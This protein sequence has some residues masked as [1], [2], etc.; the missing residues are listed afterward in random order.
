[1]KVSFDTKEWKTYPK[2]AAAVLA[3]LGFANFGDL[4][5]WV[6]STL[7]EKPAAV[8]QQALEGE[9]R[10]RAAGDSAILDSMGRGFRRLESGLALTQDYLLR[11]PQVA[12]YHQDKE[13]QDSLERAEERRRRR[14]FDREARGPWHPDREIR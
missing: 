7:L 10:A 2:Y 6:R 9:A 8:T 3:L 11:V 5:R 14:M 1:M 13:R 4:V 12:K